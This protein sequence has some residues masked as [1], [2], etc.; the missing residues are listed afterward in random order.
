MKKRKEKGR[1]GQ[2]RKSTA[3][4]SLLLCL[5]IFSVPAFAAAPPPEFVL[6]VTIRATGKAP[7]P[8]ESYTV[9][10]T[11]IDAAPLPDDADY[12]ELTLAG[13]G[14]AS[15][16]AVSF[17]TVGIYRYCLSQLAGKQSGAQY[18]TNVY[19][20]IVTVT[21][22][23][24][25]DALQS[26][27]FLVKNGKKQTGAEFVNNYGSGQETGGG[28]HKDPKPDKLIQTG[29]QNVTVWRLCGAGAALLVLGA[30]LLGR[31]RRHAWKNW[32]S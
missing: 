14:S 3:L 10:L 2:W 30:L 13:P 8:P 16:P 11:A 15:F 22:P 12:M 18:D 28:G 23:E 27:V 9:R 6:P 4:I 19:T 32:E 1:N 20:M 7:S 5:S 17:P 31:D 26:A 24:A 21:N 29:Q 25:G